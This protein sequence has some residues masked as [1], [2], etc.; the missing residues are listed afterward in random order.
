MTM[1]W[2]AVDRSQEMPL[3][4]Q[5][6]DQIR[7]SIIR[8]DLRAGERLP[9]TRQLA[10]DLHVSRIVIVEVYDQLLAEGYIESREGSG[11]YVAEGAYLEVVPINASIL[12]LG[13][14]LISVMSLL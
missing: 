8:G 10:R 1:L 14:P 9:S 11:T 6:Y 5:V 3:I 7:L 2:I 4:R 12:Q 13:F